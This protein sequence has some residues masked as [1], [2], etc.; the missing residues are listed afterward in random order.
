[1]VEMG[2]LRRSCHSRYGAPVRAAWAFS[3]SCT[4]RR[5][6]I[7][8]VFLDLWRCGGA[9]HQVLVLLNQAAHRRLD[10]L[11]RALVV[12][13]AVRRCALPGSSLA[14]SSSTSSIR[15]TAE[16]DLVV[17]MKRRAGAHPRG[18]AALNRAARRR[19]TYC[20][21]L[22]YRT[23]KEAR[24]CAPPRPC[25]A[26]TVMVSALAGINAASGSWCFR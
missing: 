19:L 9:H 3:C 18:L 4:R 6:G 20:R 21:E 13:E 8:R 15:R 5:L 23:S 16:S 12:P 14:Q 24:R 22:S 17:P 26:L 1:L 7:A 10:A 25:R 2:A 11:P